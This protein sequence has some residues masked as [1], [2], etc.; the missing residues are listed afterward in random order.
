LHDSII[1]VKKKA[2]TVNQRW[3]Q[4]ESPDG[5]QTGKFF[6]TN[7]DGLITQRQVHICRREIA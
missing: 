7:V 4:T 5:D 6:F 2:N 1:S 3:R